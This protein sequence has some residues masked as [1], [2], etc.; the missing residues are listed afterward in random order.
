MS[1]L[2]TQPGTALFL[3]PCHS[4]PWA[5]HWKEVWGD[6]RHLDVLKKERVGR[7]GSRIPPISTVISQLWNGVEQ[8]L[9]PPYE[10]SS[11]FTSTTSRFL[12]C[13]PFTVPDEADLFYEDADLFLAKLE[14]EFTTENSSTYPLPYS[15]IVTF[16]ATVPLIQS[17]LEKWEMRECA[18]FFN[19]HWHGD[20]RRGGDV[21]VYCR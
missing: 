10:T 12:T 20:W 2:R 15:N 14:A 4:T 3:M 17:W 5:S 7:I 6:A 11:Q 13:D 8:D 9:G 16:E 18:R 1:H 21:V 19:T